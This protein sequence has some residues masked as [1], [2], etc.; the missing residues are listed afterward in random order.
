MGEDPTTQP[1]PKREPEALGDGREGDV[2]HW[3]G[4]GQP[5]TN[6]SATEQTSVWG[7]SPDGTRAL[8]QSLAGGTSAGRGDTTQPQKAPWVSF[9]PQGAALRMGGAEVPLQQQLRSE[10]MQRFAGG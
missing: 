3:E 10:A 1:R 7:C 5:N 6:H 8:H 2:L 4:R 9:H